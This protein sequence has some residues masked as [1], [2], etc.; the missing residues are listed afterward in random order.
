MFETPLISIVDD[1]ALA[2][3][4]IGELVESYSEPSQPG[5][6]PRDRLSVALRNVAYWPKADIPISAVN[7]RFRG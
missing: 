2:R 4:G 6:M 3:D 7:V 5:M 1:D